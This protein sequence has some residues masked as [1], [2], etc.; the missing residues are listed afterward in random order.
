MAP[1]SAF[2]DLQEMV[3]GSMLDV[4]GG[5]NKERARPKRARGE[6]PEG[7]DTLNLSSRGFL[8]RE[9]RTR[10]G[11]KISRHPSPSPLERW[12]YRVFLATSEGNP[13]TAKT[14]RSRAEESSCSCAFVGGS[15]HNG[16]GGGAGPLC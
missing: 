2:L 10:L 1:R 7:E 12:V 8:C 11:Y 9:S 4:G 13:E 15:I 16:T 14:K 5:P 3:R 6:L